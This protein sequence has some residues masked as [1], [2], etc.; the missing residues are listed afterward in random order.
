MYTIDLVVVLQ[1]VKIKPHEELLADGALTLF[2][3]NTGRAAFVSHQ[4]VGKH[5]PDHPV[6]VGPVQKEGLQHRLHLKAC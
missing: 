2:D 1:M 6:T 4:W 5:H 3:E